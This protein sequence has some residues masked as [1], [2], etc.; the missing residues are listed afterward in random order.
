[1]VKSLFFKKLYLQSLTP[2]EILEFYNHNNYSVKKKEQLFYI[3]LWKDSISK[4]G[5]TESFNEYCI[6]N[7][8]S[9]TDISLMTSQIN[10]FSSEIK[11]PL[12]INELKK[13]LNKINLQN[14]KFDVLNKE[15]PFY[16]LLFPFINSFYSSFK[17]NLESLNIALPNQNVINQLN[18]ALYKDL[19][20][21]AS[22]VLFNEFN[23]FI[24]EEKM[25]NIINDQDEGFYYEK[26][27]DSVLLNQFQNLF[28]KYPMLSRKLVS[29]MSSYLDFVTT[30]FERFNTDI[31][32]IENSFNAELDKI[33]QLHLNL[34][35]QHNGGTTVIFEFKNSYKIVYKPVNVTITKAF[36]Q[37]LNWIKINSDNELKSFRAVDKEDYGWLE[38]VEHT[39][40]NNI[41][42]V[43][44][45]Y[46][47][48]G[49]LACITYFLNSSD[50][51]F[52]NLIAARDCPV[53]IDHETL[54]N[55]Q[56]K[57]KKMINKNSSQKIFGTVLETL[58][59]PT[60]I[61]DAPSYLSGFGSSLE[62]EQIAIIP[63]IKNCNKSNMSIVPEV[64]TKK[65]YR[66]NKP[67]L[68][69]KI[70][71]LINYQQEFKI[72]FEKIYKLIL[73]NRTQLLS[74]NSPL[75]SFK[76]LKIRFINRR[77]SVYFKILKLLTKP[78]YLEDSIKYGLKL[79]LM[80]RA[81]NVNGNWSSL[82]SSE[83]KQMLSGDIPAF[84]VNTLSN[85]IILSNEEVNI[86]RLNA[87][88]NIKS[89]I[90]KAGIDD[91][92]YQ[93]SLIDEV[94]AL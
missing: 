28:L 43:K 76:N 67:I 80:A 25:C 88:D 85:S 44:L 66:K 4:D 3:N 42:E 68:N 53:L 7:N 33:N 21:V 60:G 9:D 90:K 84:Y 17:K 41:E 81:Y 18:D 23:K 29:K 14:K 74:K 27:V 36:N 83:R 8:L 52:E 46:E 54:I 20:N 45:Y 5:S 75:N 34:G 30:M 69:N 51:H 40:C 72:G 92:Q 2:F 61:K 78:E 24:K 91:F 93:I 10:D 37:F 73:N 11:F 38:Y 56:L 26:F 64:L 79:E 59:L 82:L 22:L 77:T 12:W 57:R 31:L 39:E 19:F 35:D 71:N 47:R 58:L 32:E 48:A 62:L 15:K 94:I 16:Q 50:Y 87:L 1:M 89:K 70:E 65:L 63:K 6:A 86:F 55:P 13:V 49:M